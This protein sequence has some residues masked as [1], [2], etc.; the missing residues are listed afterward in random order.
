MYHVTNKSPV[1]ISELASDNYK[2]SSYVHTCSN[3]KRKLNLDCLLLDSE[4]FLY[5]SV[6]IVAVCL[7]SDLVRPCLGNKVPTL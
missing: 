6:L 1:A 5:S 2:C 3:N 7:Q 4:L